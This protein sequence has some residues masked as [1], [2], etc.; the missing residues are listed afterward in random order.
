MLFPFEFAFNFPFLFLEVDVTMAECRG[1]DFLDRD[2]KNVEEDD[3]CFGEVAIKGTVGDDEPP[4]VVIFL[5]GG[6]GTIGGGGGGGTLDEFD[7][8]DIKRP[9]C[10]GGIEY[11]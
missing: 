1:P 2:A 8:G 3:F 7:A 9:F 4:F 5:G 10:R 6:G 11:R